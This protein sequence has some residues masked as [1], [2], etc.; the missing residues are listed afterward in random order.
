MEIRNFLLSLV[1]LLLFPVVTQAGSATYPNNENN[2]NSH[3]KGV[4]INDS[5]KWALEH[6]P[7]LRILKSN[8]EALSY[9]LNQAK[10]GLFPSL[11]L[12]SS[13]GYD[14]H[15]DITTRQD[16]AEPADDQWDNRREVALVLRQLLFDGGVNSQIS[17]QQ[18]KLDSAKH[19]VK[20]NAESIALDAVIA[21]LSVIR[22]RMLLA[23]AEKNI[24]DHEEIL[25]KLIKRQKGGVGN[26]ADVTQTQGRLSRARASLYSLKADLLASNA[27]YEKIVGREPGDLNFAQSP[28]KTPLELDKTLDMTLKGNPKILA[29]G[30]DVDEFEA[31]LDMAGSADYP[32]FFLELSRN[33][34]HQVEGDPSWQDTNV[35]MIKMDWNLFNGGSDKA[36]KQAARARVQQSIETLQNEILEVTRQTQNTWAQYKSTNERIKVY[37]EATSYNKIT[38]DAYLKQFDM[39]QRSLLDVLYAENEL[40]QSAGLLIT[41][42]INEVIAAGRILALGGRLVDSEFPHATLPDVAQSNEKMPQTIASNYSQ[43]NQGQNNKNTEVNQ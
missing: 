12:S 32:K 4:S 27:Y 36:A 3:A 2:H 19:R 6:S 22:Q 28:A 7:R 24:R 34:R 38:L 14:K 23:L 37:N 20:D 43:G 8:H 9:E 41:A 21:H 10:G 29:F 35:A 13:Y 15:S 1:V 18:A 31:K 25:A 5:I 30:T 42:Q 40:F 17:I 16:D 26:S 39:G 11:N 33:Y